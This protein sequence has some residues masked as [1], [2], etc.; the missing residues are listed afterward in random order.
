MKSK[1]ELI[2]LNKEQKAFYNNEEAYVKPNLFSR[3][4]RGFRNGPLNGF[5][6][7]Y[8]LRQR[9]YDLHK[10]WMGDLS[11]QKVL[12][13]GCLR[14]NSLSLYM[15]E[16]AKEYIGID[17]SDV[18]IA[19]LQKKLDALDKPAAKALAVDFLSDDFEDGE[20]D[21]IY[22]F[23]V[24]HHF[25]N[26]DVLM[27]RLVEKLKPNGMVISFDPIETSAPVQ[28]LRKLYRP[29]QQDKDWEWP[30]N[31]DT[32]PMIEGYFE[33]RELRGVLGR[34]KYGLLLH[35]LPLPDAYKK[36]KIAAQIQSDWRPQSPREVL[37]CMQVTMRL[38]KR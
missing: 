20:F 17:L 38:V 7:T 21:L 9:M 10:V 18:A 6:K 31:K 27:Q 13:L 26:F 2:Q 28:V 16:H 23:G 30:F 11:D 35:L 3:M 14:G 29:F 4:W 8:A 33:I 24:L 5:Q 34:S 32:F 1:E 15:A 36:R 12:D 19:D 25:Q 37:N 22:A